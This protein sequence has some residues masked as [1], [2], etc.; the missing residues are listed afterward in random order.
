[1]GTPVVKIPGLK[2]KS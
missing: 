1:M 2:N